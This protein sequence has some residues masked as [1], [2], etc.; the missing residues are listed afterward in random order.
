MSN[1][2][3]ILQPYKG[4]KTRHKCPDCGETGRFVRY[5]DKVS[6]SYISDKVGRCDREDSCGYHY[7]PSS[8]FSDNP[9]VT[10]EDSN[11]PVTDVT[12]CY[13]EV[14]YISRG[15]LDK[16]LKR[17]HQSDLFPFLKKLFTYNIAAELC[18]QYFI[19][20]NKD[21]KTVFWQVDRSGNIRQ[22]K[23][24]K[25]DS[26]TGR[27]D[28]QSGAFF[29]GKK[30]LNDSQANLQQCFFGEFLLSKNSRQPVAIVESE[31]TAVI[32]SIY[33]PQFIWIATGGKTG[34]KWTEE[35]VCKVLFRRNV[36]LFP[37]LNAY[38]AWKIKG[39]LLASVAGCKVVVSDLL[40]KLASE[41]DKKKGLDL[42]DYLLLKTDS[43][44][45]ALT[46][47][48]YPVI[49]DYQEQQIA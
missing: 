42:A 35:R 45:L 29:A 44:G 34:C 38:D 19:G 13:A 49:W 12:P 6:G 25:Y 46:D 9:S 1:Y 21:N 2:K 26:V 47:F 24:M 3:Y 30:I 8:F 39:N 20:A 36:I 28:K 17:F 33:F 27:R 43:S 41:E 7:T 48:E 22:A 37:D 14:Q 32:A 11:T 5:V 15:V 31:K 23:V 4:K 10:I 16:T 40:E 18:K